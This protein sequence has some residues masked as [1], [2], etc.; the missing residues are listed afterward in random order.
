MG[1][2]GRCSLGC[3][4]QSQYLLWLVLWGCLSIKAHFLELYADSC[5]VLAVG[6]YPIL[7]LSVTMLE[8]IAENLG[9]P[10]C[11]LTNQLCFDCADLP[12]SIG[13][14][15]VVGVIKGAIHLV[16]PFRLCRVSYLL[17][18]LSRVGQLQDRDGRL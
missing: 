1:G 17:A 10:F 15:E 14:D 18:N 3:G 16:V 13:E 7:S 12:P 11:I 4:A 9:D 8:A 6:L 5:N 2:V